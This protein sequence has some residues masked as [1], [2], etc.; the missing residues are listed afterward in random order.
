MIITDIGQHSVEEIN[1]GKAGADYG[2]PYREGTFVFDANANRE[3]VYPLP[4]NDSRYTE[5]VIQFDHD[6]GNAVSGGYVYAGNKVSQLNGKYIFGDISNG[7]LF[8]SEESEIIEGQQAALYRLNVEI[9]EKY[10]S[11]QSINPNHRVDLR[12]GIDGS[13][14][15]YIFTKSNGKIYKVVNCKIAKLPKLQD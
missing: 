9:N 10:K 14:E 6:E 2:W 15:I 4:P 1:L 11:L 12:F 5:P 7:N 13:G 3:M 8:Y